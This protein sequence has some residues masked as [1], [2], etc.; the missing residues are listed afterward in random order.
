M[1]GSR[2]W[3]EAESQA[4]Y[5]AFVVAPQA[6]A[7]QGG[8]A[9]AQCNAPIQFPE[10]PAA[11]MGLALEIL[12]R[13]QEEFSIDPQRLYVTGMSLGGCGTWDVIARYPGRF[14][15]AV[16]LVG[17][18]DPRTAPRLVDTPLWVFNGAR[19]PFVTYARSMVAAIRKAGGKPL[20]T[21]YADR[22]HNVGD[23][24]YCEPDLLPWVF[25]ERPK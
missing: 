9:D 16:V 6:P 10:R 23:R 8:W 1:W 24:T 11:A 2:I 22:G 3:A 14:A 5:P 25:A 7:G 21:E 15:A 18:G 4:L 12:E 20:Y 19:D 17:N 13:L